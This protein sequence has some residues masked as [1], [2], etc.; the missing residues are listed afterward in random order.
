MKSLFFCLSL[1][2][3]SFTAMAGNKTYTCSSSDQFQTSKI[4]EASVT[5][6]EG[7]GNSIKGANLYL[8]SDDEILLETSFRGVRFV[9]R[10]NNLVMSGKKNSRVNPFGDDE[11]LILEGFKEKITFNELTSNLVLKYES[12]SGPVGN[13]GGEGFT[14]NCN[15]SN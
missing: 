2:S 12:I 3:V 5:F 15:Q 8:L 14:L 1:L 6:I 4:S 10:T 11:Y 7:F 13:R 9:E